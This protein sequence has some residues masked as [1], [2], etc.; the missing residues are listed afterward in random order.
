M[1]GSVMLSVGVHSWFHPVV[2]RFAIHVNRRA[3]FRLAALCCLL[4]RARAG[5]ARAVL[6]LDRGWKFTRADVP[7]AVRPDFDDSS[8]RDVDLPHDFSIEGGYSRTNTPQNAWLPAG[9]GMYRK[10]FSLSGEDLKKE[11]LLRFEGVYMNAAVYLNGGRVG[12]RPYGFLGF[13]CALSPF[14]REGENVLTVLA[15]DTPAPTARFYHG[16]GIYG[17]V[18][19]HILPRTHVLLN[20]GVFART[21]SAG[22]DAAALAVDT[23]F[24]AAAPG[25]LTVFHRLED[26]DGREAAVSEKKTAAYEAG[27]H[28]VAHA[29]TVPHPRLWSTRDPCLYTLRTFILDG[30]CV[31]DRVSGRIGIRTARFDAAA[32]FL[33]NG[34][35]VKLKGVCEHLELSP[36]GAAVP[37]KMIEWRIKRLL[38]MGCNA[39]RTAHNP[40]TPTFYRK[41][42]ELGM[43]VVDEVFD[44]W[45][46]KGA[47]DYGGRFFRRHWKKDVAYWVRRDRC[48]P[49]VILW[50]IGNEVGGVRDVHGISGVING[51]DGTR[52]TTGGHIFHGV[53][54][55]GFNGQGGQPGFLENFHAS[56]PDRP[57]VLTEVPHT[58]QT[59]GFYRVLTWW[60]DRG[61]PRF[62]FA[63][64][65]DE[66]IFSGG[67]RRYRSSYDNCG[68]RC[69]ARICWKRTEATPWI[70]GE[71]R[72]TG[73]DCLGEAQFMGAEFP[74]RNY[75]CGVIDL[76]GFAKDH[77]Y[78]Y[79]S[80]WTERPMVHLLPHWTHPDLAEGTIVPVV[81]Y[82]NCGEVELFLN[83]RSLGRKKEG[84]LPEFVWKVPYR[85]GELKAVG[86]AGGAPAARKVFRTAGP[87]ARLRLEADNRSLAVGGGDFSLL[88]VSAVDA[89]GVFVPWAHDRVEFRVSGPARAAGYENGDPMDGTDNRAP[90]RKLF[91]GL[92]RG[93]Y[94]S[95]D[96]EGPVEVAAAAILGRRLFSGTA[97]VA[98]SVET[99]MLRGERPESR[100][101]IRY[102]LDGTPPAADA[103]RYTRP[104]TL[105][106]GA[107]VRALILRD[108][109]PFMTLRDTF[110]KGAEPPFSDPRFQ[111]KAAGKGAFTGPRDP[112]LAAKWREGDRIYETGRNGDFYV[113]RADKKILV[114]WWWYDY[115]DDTAENPAFTGR[116]EIKWRDS[117]E[118]SSLKLTDQAGGTLLIRTGGKTRT[119]RRARP[120]AG[121]ENLRGG[122]PGKTPALRPQAEA[123]GRA[124]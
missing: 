34:E 8:W 96:G 26:A 36:F 121:E 112:E 93:Y 94:R 30:T 111:R 54:V 7:A 5:E 88:T 87:P 22:R 123:G 67:H 58:L 68:V 45:R 16:G 115:P 23:E 56:H 83:G 109:K 103:R 75:S 95:T 38:S 19:L 73:F 43:M 15:D 107:D 2:G 11:I 21:V 82:S 117:G 53:G 17:H 91:H 79:Q 57:V 41:C 106:G 78:F 35:N 80:R 76:A 89:R 10:R 18:S 71:F 120:A 84:A 104:F 101:E 28:R 55:A 85:P 39:I 3:F 1:R 37:G 48:H 33:L 40:F 9:K 14:A 60:R 6:D 113:H 118:I 63:P 72:W 74:K 49:S 27:A 110:A 69:P 32:G 92:A 97:Q 42:D 31:V 50:S 98:I 62:E 116:G 99:A 44:G 86:Y 29:L 12:G 119:M 13:D 114:G 90:F 66:E 108:G 24:R 25:R 70:S 65:G 105:S 77:F 102:T 20:G 52:P 124:G 4:A 81:A 61:N 46:R 64:Y 47:N 100:F 122:T 59:R 51:L